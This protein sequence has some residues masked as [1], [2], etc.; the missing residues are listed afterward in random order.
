ME[1]KEFLYLMLVAVP[2]ILFGTG[3]LTGS[4]K[5]QLHR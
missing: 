4:G 2:W 3:C 1:V 5:K